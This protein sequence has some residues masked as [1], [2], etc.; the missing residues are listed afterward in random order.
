M[1]IGSICTGYGGL[2]MA[3]QHVFGGEVAWTS[4]IS[5]GACKLA[6]HRWPDIPN[7]GDITTVSWHTVPTVDIICGGTPCQDVSIAGRRAGMTAGTRSNLWESMREAIH[8]IKPSIVVWENVPGARSARAA[9]AGDLESEPGPVGDPDGKPVL[10]ALG[11]VLGDLAG[12]GFDAEWRSIRASDVGACHR[13]ERV[14]VLA[15][16]PDR[17]ADARGWPPQSASHEHRL[18]RGYLDAQ[19]LDL[20]PTVR[21]SSSTG[22]G[23]HGDGGADL[24]TVVSLLPTPSVADVRGGRKA[25]SGARSDELLLNGLAADERFGDYAPAVARQEKAF[26]IPAPDP[27]E[28]GRNGTPRLSARFTEWMQGLP[29][30]WICDVPGITRTEAIEL[31]GNG[32]VPQQAEAALADMLPSITEKATA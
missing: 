22:P 20:M 24:Q 1:R 28:P 5:T 10:R 17:I 26:G 23:A 12:L 13:R 6:A 8:V 19:I 27:T 21:A 4:D 14:F 2:D 25:R 11:R 16:H 31:A 18:A 7:L 29:A 32:V 9:S 30:G 3:V 15:W